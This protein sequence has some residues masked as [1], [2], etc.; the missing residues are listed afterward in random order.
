MNIEIARRFFMYCTFINWGV[1][2]LWFFG[3]AFA[4]DLLKD[5]NEWSLRRKVENFDALNI[6]GIALYKVGIIFFNLVPW[7]ALTIVS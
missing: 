3:F 7:I 4:H 2:V 5:L 6:S 1:L